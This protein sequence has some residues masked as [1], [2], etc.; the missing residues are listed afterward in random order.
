[1]TR[2]ALIVACV[3]AAA[4]GAAGAVTRYALVIGND[5]GDRDEMA[6]RYAEHDAEHFA[7][8][9]VD[10]GGFAPGDVIVLRGGDADAARAALIALNDRIR[11]AGP[12]DTMLVVYYSGHADAEALHL[13]ATNFALTQLEQLV[14]GSPAAFRLLVVDACRSGALTR[15]KG[16]KPANSF[17]I[18]LGDTL[19]AD[20]VVFWT[21]SAASEEAQESDS[22]KGSFFSHFLVSG[23]AGPADADNDGAV[24][25]AEAYEYARA[26][27]LRASSR[28]LAGT[29]H[30]TFRDELA[31][32]DAI[33]LTR[34]GAADPR[35]GAIRVPA[36]RD[37]I[38][39]AGSA[40]GPVVAEVGVHDRTRRLNV[41]AGKYFIR[42]RGDTHLLEGTIDVAAGVEH[43]VADR[44]L[45]RVDYIEV[46]AKG[47]IVVPRIPDAVEAGALVRTALIDGGDPCVGAIA[48]YA[49]SL[50]WLTLT[51]RFSA[52][53]EHVAN[54][55]VAT[56]TDDVVADVRLS[57]AWHAAAWTFAVQVEAGG[58]VL[59]QHFTTEGNAPARTSAGALFGG[60]G[61]VEL[62]LAH[63]FYASLA[64]EVDSYI[65][66]QDDMPTTRWAPVLALGGVLAVGMH[67]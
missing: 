4:T 51:P 16:G 20:G 59:H 1:M 10:L 28:T 40:E 5:T 47:A 50:A 26:A 25:T 67:L 38:V 24:T 65:L 33:V 27:T 63:D 32:R 19:A 23:L 11:T 9:L 61:S 21:A 13:G 12:A 8:T 57:H 15:V 64:G 14:R 49:I 7:A 18:A 55:F 56:A 58:A 39:L 60:G 37:M 36:D 30:P 6:L 53:R 43:V 45:A 31:G 54:T 2:L 52:C 17:P 66:H 35:R 34:P 3:L 44:E 29:Q 62:A 22:I 48:G 46:A 41:R 42:A